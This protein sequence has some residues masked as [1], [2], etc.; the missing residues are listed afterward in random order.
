VIKNVKFDD[1]GAIVILNGKTET[2]PA[3]FSVQLVYA[4]MG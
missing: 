4:A 3:E 2:G 1:Y